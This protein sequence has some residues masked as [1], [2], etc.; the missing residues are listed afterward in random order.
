MVKEI[1]AFEEKLEMIRRRCLAGNRQP[2]E[3]EE[4]E[5]LTWLVKLEEKVNKIEMLKDIAQ[6]CEREGRR[7]TPEEIRIAQRLCQDLPENEVPAFW[8]Q[9]QRPPLKPELP[10]NE[11]VYRPAQTKSGRSLFPQGG[12]D[13]G[14]KSMG[15]YWSALVKDR[16]DSRLRRLEVKAMEVGTFSEGGALVP[17]AF[18]NEVLGLIVERS[19]ILSGA[20][21]YPMSGPGDV[22]KIP[23]VDDADH[24]KD[25]G[26][27]VAT[28]SGEGGTLGP[29]QIKTRQV[30]LAPKKLTLLVKASREFMQDAVNAERFVRE[31]MTAE[32]AW[33]VDHALIRGTGAGQPLGIL[34]APDLITVAKETGQLAATFV[35]E[36]ACSMYQ[37]LD[38]AGDAG[39]IWLF[40]PSLKKQLFTM[41]IMIGTGGVG[42]W[43]ALKEASG[44]IILLA[45]PAYWSEHLAVAGQVG[46]T[47]LVNPKALAVAIR[48]QAQIDVSGH[49]Y[50]L[51]DYVA[52]RL[53][54]RLDA[55]SKYSSPL[56]LHDGVS[57][58]SNFITLE[59][60]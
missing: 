35:W 38:P 15:E 44:S 27:L 12:D 16:T 10:G 24:S 1:V 58:V 6:V 45:K 43:P 57:Q 40:S 9:S 19:V 50:F 23:A 32:A 21:V 30:D 3:R 54:L 51:T 55:Q 33:Q 60:R 20:D 17:E 41:G 8:K 26:G 7:P 18:A 29:D 4:K 25:R 28:W 46:D 39:A 53:T 36:N 22:L 13:G 47:L 48:Q 42:Y 56:T 59:A 5:L 49:V 34:A 14:F 31:T 52:F 37:A 11:L 2:N